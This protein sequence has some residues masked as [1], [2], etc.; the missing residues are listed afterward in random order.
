MPSVP[1]DAGV[2][3][4]D[5]WSLLRPRT[6]FASAQGRPVAVLVTVVL[7]LFYGFLG[8]A[9]W[10]PVRHRVFDTYQSI[11]PRQVQALPVVLVEIDAASVT[12]LGQWPWPR[13]RLARSSLCYGR[14]KARMP[15]EP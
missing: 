12:A 1:A 9:L 14:F 15:A 4:G 6:W 11:A 7:A 3:H 8:Q 10:E 5:G 13:T 2:V